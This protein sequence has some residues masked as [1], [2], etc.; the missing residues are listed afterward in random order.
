MSDLHI[1]TYFGTME[2]ETIE[3]QIPTVFLE[4]DPRCLHHGSTGNSIVSKFKINGYYFTNP[5]K[6]AKSILKIH[7]N[8]KKFKLDFF[9]NASVKKFMKLYLNK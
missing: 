1:S 4:A 9:R 7:E 8:T 3:N 2:L 5:Y 6:A